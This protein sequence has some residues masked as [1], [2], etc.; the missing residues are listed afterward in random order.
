MR[1]ACG[2]SSTDNA[3]PRIPRTTYIHLNPL[4]G[5][6][7][8]ARSF[9]AWKKW[10]IGGHICQDYCMSLSGSK[11]TG[12]EWNGQYPDRNPWI[13]IRSLT[14]SPDCVP[15]VGWSKLIKHP[16]SQV[17]HRSRIVLI[18][19]CQVEVSHVGGDLVLVTGNISSAQTWQ[20][21]TT[22]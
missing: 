13:C 19:V 15:V 1:T 17:S 5:K 21:S 12:N 20:I 2:V 8:K 3:S 16:G 9:L 10:A 18:I 11:S 14:V 4:Q 7:F 22:C 6:G